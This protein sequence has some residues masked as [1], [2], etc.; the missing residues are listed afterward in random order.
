VK[1]GGTKAVKAWRQRWWCSSCSER[2]A[3]IGPAS[4][5]TR[6]ATPEAVHMLGIGA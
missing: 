2:I 3:M 6:S 5:K 1:R 4:I